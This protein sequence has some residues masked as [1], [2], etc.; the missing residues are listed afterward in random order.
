MIDR[1]KPH[2]GLPP[3][4]THAALAAVP[5][6]IAALGEKDNAEA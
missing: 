3:G 5:T 2:F 1:N 4:L 6:V